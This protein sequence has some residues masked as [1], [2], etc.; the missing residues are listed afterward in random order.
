MIKKIAYALFSIILLLIF[1]CLA[2]TYWANYFP[3]KI[4]PAPFTSNTS[5]AIPLHQKIKILT[6]NAQIFAGGLNNQFFFDGGT[7]PWPSEK[8]IRETTARFARIIKQ[9]NPD[10]ILFQE[11]DVNST[12]T[13]HLNQFELIRSALPAT[14]SAWSCTPYWKT[15]YL[16][17]KNLG[18]VDMQ[19]CTFSKYR[20]VNATRY[21]L[22]R[23]KHA[24]EI[25]DAFLIKPAILDT[26]IATTDGHNLHVMNIHT[27]AAFDSDQTATIE[28]SQAAYNLLTNFK[29][30]NARAIIGGDFNS[31]AKPDLIKYVYPASQYLYIGLKK[32]PVA[33]LF[34]DFKA[35]PSMEDLTSPQK[36]KWFTY[37]TPR[38]PE[39]VADRTIDYF[40]MTPNIQIDETEVIKKGT[41][42]LS[43]H[44]P[45]MVTIHLTAGKN[46]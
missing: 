38:M 32:S 41:R 25:T 8:T 39:R 27:N 42:Y 3:K 45:V 14:Y 16:L 11:V 15:K 22:P 37:L 2:F 46:S 12:R 20:I 35:A 40:F 18:R 28:Q 17:Y 10:I 7:D 36:Q 26:E 31:L 5:S 9:E 21:D 44:Y 19:L 30:D 1:A 29:S 33:D 24:N 34:R 23:K 13:H 6:W 4:Q 43:D